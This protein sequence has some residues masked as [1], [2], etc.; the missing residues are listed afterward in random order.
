MQSTATNN[1]QHTCMHNLGRPVYRQ[2]AEWI[3]EHL[4][5]QD[6]LIFMYHFANMWAL[7]RPHGMGLVAWRPPSFRAF[8]LV[9]QASAGKKTKLKR[10]YRKSGEIEPSQRSPAKS[11]RS[12]AVRD[13]WH[14]LAPPAH[15]SPRQ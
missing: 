8:A 10:V 14:P 11:P 1:Q 7:R 13:E 9:Q 12:S 15:T 5:Y 3:R 6:M 2:R 4:R